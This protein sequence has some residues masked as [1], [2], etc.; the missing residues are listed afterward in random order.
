MMKVPILN[1]PWCLYNTLWHFGLVMLNHFNI[2]IT[3]AAPKLNIIRLN[4]TYN[5]LV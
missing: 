5:L 2:R 4:W 3:G 1:V